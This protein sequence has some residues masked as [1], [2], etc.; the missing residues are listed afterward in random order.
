MP[1]NLQ[2]QFGQR[3]QSLRKAAGMSQEALAEAVGKSVD[4]ISN[5]ERGTLGT[6]FATVEKLALALKA[7]VYSLFEFVPPPP[8]TGESK[9]SLKVSLAGIIEKFDKRQLK[10]LLNFAETVQEF[11]ATER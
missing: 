7:P 1:Q 10:A 8:K 9:E 2:H 11:S 4:T 6:S 3:V 5:I